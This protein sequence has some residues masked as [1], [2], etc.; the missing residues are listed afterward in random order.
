MLQLPILQLL[1]LLAI[2][3]HTR[4]FPALFSVFILAPPIPSILLLKRPSY[5]HNLAVKLGVH[6]SLTT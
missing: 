4:L 3:F 6:H 5:P 1:I 2:L